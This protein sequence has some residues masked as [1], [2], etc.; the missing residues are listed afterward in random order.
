ML[1]YKLRQ[2][3][4]DGD[5]QVLRILNHYEIHIIPLLNPDGYEYSQTTVKTLI[6]YNKTYTLKTKN[7]FLFKEPNVAKESS[8][9]YWIILH[10]YGFEP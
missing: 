2:G 3:W 4:N 6:K 10:W 7:I 9:K 5:A 8:S 1:N